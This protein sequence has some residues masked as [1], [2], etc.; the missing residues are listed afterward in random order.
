MDKNKKTNLYKLFILKNIMGLALIK[1]KIMPSSPDTNLTAIEEKAKGI[2]AKEQGKNIKIEK[3]PIAFGL[4]ALIVGFA[5][6]ET[7][8]SDNLLKKLQNIPNVSSVEIIDF[9]RAIG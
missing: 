8:D 1:I 5:R 3:E 7:L 6:E 2:T 4:N 9:R